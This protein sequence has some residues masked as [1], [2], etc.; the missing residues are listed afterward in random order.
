MCTGL[1]WKRDFVVTAECSKATLALHSVRKF[2]FFAHD[3]QMFTGPQRKHDFWSPR[4]RG[5]KCAL[6]CSETVICF[7]PPKGSMSLLDRRKI[8]CSPL[9]RKRILWLN[10]QRLK[11]TFA[12]RPGRNGCFFLKRSLVCSENVDFFHLQ[13]D[14]SNFCSTSLLKRLLCFR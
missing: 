6:V 13:S 8:K 7:S 11:V 4:N 3:L 1:Q 14:L 10:P 12:L 5:T 9:Q 2:H